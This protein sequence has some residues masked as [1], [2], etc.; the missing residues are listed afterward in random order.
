M[1]RPIFY[2]IEWADGKIWSAHSP[3][4]CLL[5]TILFNTLTLIMSGQMLWLPTHLPT[6]ESLGFPGFLAVGE[7]A[8]FPT[9]TE[10][11]QAHLNGGLPSTP[12]HHFFITSTTQEEGI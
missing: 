8:E 7:R 3:S 11:R 2:K 1:M 6:G 4:R 9:P 12:L 5:K 10:Y